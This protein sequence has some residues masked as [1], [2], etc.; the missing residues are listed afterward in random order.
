MKIRKAVIKHLSQATPLWRACSSWSSAVR[1]CLSSNL[2]PCIEANK[3]RRCCGCKSHRI[4]LVEAGGVVGRWEL[5]ERRRKGRLNDLHPSPQLRTWAAW[6][7][8]DPHIISIR[9]Q[10]SLFIRRGS[11]YKP[12]RREWLRQSTFVTKR[13]SEHRKQYRRFPQ[14]IST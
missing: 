8:I 9:A 10:A 5:E 1:F 7:E 3:V 12:G 4:S 11:S 13:F 2:S 6:Q 14:W